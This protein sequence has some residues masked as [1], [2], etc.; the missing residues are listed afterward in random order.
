VVH[1]SKS[2]GARN[3]AG[4]SNPLPISTARQGPDLGLDAIIPIPG[5]FARLAFALGFQQIIPPQGGPE[6][7]HT[8]VKRWEDETQ[9]VLGRRGG[10]RAVRSC[11][12]HTGCL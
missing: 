3:L 12:I 10:I 11:Q 4:G 8:C 2:K 5:R 1:E 9:H 6:E 7:D